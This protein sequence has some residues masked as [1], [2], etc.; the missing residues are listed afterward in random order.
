MNFYLYNT[1]SQ[2]ITWQSTSPYVVD[3]KPGILPDNVIQLKGE[4]EPQL[5][6]AVY[7]KQWQSYQEVDLVNKKIYNQM[8]FN[9]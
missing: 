2:Q 6:D 3:G 1:T 4:V 8:A 7:G 5:E 9:R